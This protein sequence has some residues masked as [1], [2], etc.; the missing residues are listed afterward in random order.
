[1]HL[2]LDKY[3]A[4]VGVQVSQHPFN[5]NLPIISVPFYGIKKILQL[6]KDYL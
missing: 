6:L 2:F 4:P 1:M 3:P 5:N